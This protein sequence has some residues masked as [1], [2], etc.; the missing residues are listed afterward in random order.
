M[1][2]VFDKFNKMCRCVCVSHS[3]SFQSL[4]HLSADISLSQASLDPPQL[5]PHSLD[6]KAGLSHW[7]REGLC[8]VCVLWFSSGDIII[9][10]YLT[11]RTDLIIDDVIFFIPPE[12]RYQQQSSYSVH[13]NLMKIWDNVWVIFYP[14]IKWYFF[15]HQISF[16]FIILK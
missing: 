16:G 8:C 10:W 11:S 14:E 4:E 2:H 5:N 1:W 12:G 9:L 3:K 13:V 6:S 15:W 7:H